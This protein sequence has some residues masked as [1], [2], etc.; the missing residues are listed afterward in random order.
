MRSCPRIDQV[1]AKSCILLCISMTGRKNKTDTCPI[2]SD[3]RTVGIRVCDTLSFIFPTLCHLQLHAGN[4][5]F[6]PSEGEH[7]YTDA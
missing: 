3:T 6:V 1:T 4:S 2:I 7:N 5:R